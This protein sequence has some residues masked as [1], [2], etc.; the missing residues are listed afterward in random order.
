[1]AAG[2]REPAVHQWAADLVEAAVAQRHTDHARTL[3]RLV[4]E[5]A[6]AFSRPWVHAVAAR[7]RGMLA[8]EGE[9][10]PYF[11]E[12]LAWHAQT[13]APFER[14]RT[15]LWWGRRLRRDRRKIEARR[16][17]EAALDGFLELGARPWTNMTSRELRASGATLRRAD[18]H[19]R[20]ELT[21]QEH[22]IAGLV[23]AGASNKDVAATMYLSPKTIE[24]HLSRIY[25]KLDVR[26]RYELIQLMASRK[27][28][29]R[30]LDTTVAA[31]ARPGGA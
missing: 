17:L 31:S 30:H 1:V 24:T 2:Q 29:A 19:S 10:D 6:V 12:A 28:D 3:A 22:Q 15:H 25:R 27:A 21:P 14:A 26:S 11:T 23:I 13:I 4:E 16:E 7:A 5:L 20:D 18:P 8:G 9:Y